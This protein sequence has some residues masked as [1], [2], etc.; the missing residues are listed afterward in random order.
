MSIN[1]SSHGLEPDNI[2]VTIICCIFIVIG[3]ILI[4]S[5]ICAHFNM[6]DSTYLPITGKIIDIDCERFIINRDHD[7]YHCTMTIEYEVDNKIL[8]TR[9]QTDW[10]EIYYVGSDF[11]MYVERDNP[12]QV[13][14]PYLSD[15]FL[16]T[17]FCFCGILIICVTIGS[18]TLKI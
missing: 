15:K 9:I 8:R 5:G 17:A 6:Y 13:Y 1:N 11:F 18:M 10:H 7:Q 3:I 4:I 2:Y 12:I 14:T 16:F